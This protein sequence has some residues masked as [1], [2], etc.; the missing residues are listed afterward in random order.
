MTTKLLTS[1]VAP[2]CYQFVF[3]SSFF[4]D[5]SIQVVTTIF[6]PVNAVT[7]QTAISL[8]YIDHNKASR[9]IELTGKEYEQILYSVAT[10]PMH[11]KLLEKQPVAELYISSNTQLSIVLRRKSAGFGSKEYVYVN[12][13]DLAIEKE[14]TQAIF[15]GA[16]QAREKL[17]QAQQTFAA[18]L[19]IHINDAL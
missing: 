9:R 15:D 2:L 18:R 17:A 4:A 12:L 11:L 7:L 19:Q 6:S 5:S 13:P 16:G 10:A 14:V 3:R 8:S 1:D